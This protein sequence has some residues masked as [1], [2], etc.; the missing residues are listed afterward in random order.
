M[1]SPLSVWDGAD[2][3]KGGLEMRGRRERGKGEGGGRGAKGWKRRVVFFGGGGFILGLARQVLKIC[4]LREQFGPIHETVSS[5]H[6][7]HMTKMWK[8]SSS[9]PTGVGS[10][11]H[12]EPAELCPTLEDSWQALALAAVQRP[13]DRENGHVEKRNQEWQKRPSPS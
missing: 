10:H 11:G 9:L 12:T 3:G 5:L 6:V 8:K 7:V 1:V 13:E 2:C 4:L